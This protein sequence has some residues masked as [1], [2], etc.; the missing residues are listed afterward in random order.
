MKTQILV[1]LMSQDKTKKHS[2]ASEYIRFKICK[3]MGWDLFTYNAQPKWFIDQ[4]IQ[5]EEVEVEYK[6][7]TVE[8][9]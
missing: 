2:V 9:T 6:N 4:L 1:A 8:T 3:L 5:L 7:R